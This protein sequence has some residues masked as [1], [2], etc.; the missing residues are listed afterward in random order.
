ME[1]GVEGAVAADIRFVTAATT[2]T[3]A[4]AGR[5]VVNTVW[6]IGRLFLSLRKGLL[7]R[8]RSWTGGSSTEGSGSR[9]LLVPQFQGGVTG[10]LRH[11]KYIYI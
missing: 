11:G 8:R 9:G 7:H 6:E 1:D 10:V 4:A 3:A 2:A 5:V